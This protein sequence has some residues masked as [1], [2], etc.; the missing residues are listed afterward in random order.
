MIALQ[1]AG[2]ILGCYVLTIG[3]VVAYAAYT[4]RKGRS[5]AARLTEE[6]RPW[7]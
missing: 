2:K 5:L 4:V 6:E 7:T 3:G 1:Y